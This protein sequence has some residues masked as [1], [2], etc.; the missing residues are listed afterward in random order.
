M[1]NTQ[2]KSTHV[3]TPVS[4]TRNR[5]PHSDLYVRL[6]ET[7]QAKLAHMCHGAFIATVKL[8]AMKCM[9]RS[10]SSFSSG[11][12]NLLMNRVPPA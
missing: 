1:R 2:H 6:C 4:S 8:R 10:S 9:L 12:R 3:R 5:T 11:V 7:R